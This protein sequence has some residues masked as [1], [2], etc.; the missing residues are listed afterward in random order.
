ME[1]L[2]IFEDGIR[3]ILKLDKVP[4]KDIKE[5]GKAVFE[6]IKNLR[7]PLIKKKSA[8]FFN[9]GNCVN[10]VDEIHFGEQRL[11]L[12]ALNSLRPIRELDDREFKF[13][14][15]LFEKEKSR[16]KKNE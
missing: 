11:Y 3:K 12:G 6:V 7:N 5:M 1:I 9:H 14:E 15:K 10:I 4:E 13:V 2:Y 16:R 8:P